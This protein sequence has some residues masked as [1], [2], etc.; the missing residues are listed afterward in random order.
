MKQI[1]DNKQSG[2][3]RQRGFTLLEIMVVIVILG[4][5]AGLM[6]PSLMGSKEKADKQKAVADVVTLENALDMYKLDNGRYPT[7]E[8]GLQS[9]VT[10]PT[11]EPIPQNYRSDGYIRRLPKDPWGQAYQMR[12]PG[13][14]GSIDIFSYGPDGKDAVDH[15]IGNW[16]DNN[17]KSDN[18]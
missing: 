18:Q 7:N 4:L 17:G 6:I 15:Y 1:S 9:L 8:Q 10:K 5:L 11:Q 12:N 2:Y 14:H 13:E 16:G 3:R